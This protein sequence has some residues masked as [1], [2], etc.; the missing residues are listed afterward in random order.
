[1]ARTRFRQVER[2]RRFDGGDWKK[3]PTALR[4]SEVGLRWLEN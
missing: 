2:L 1:M 4:R 3:L